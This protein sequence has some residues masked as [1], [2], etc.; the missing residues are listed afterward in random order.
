VGT[1]AILGRHSQNAREIII[2]A[3]ENVVIELGARHLTLDAVAAKAG[4]SKGGLL[5]HFPNKEALLHAMLDRRVA[6]L[7]E[8]R[9]QKLALLPQNP[10][11]VIIAHVRSLLERDERTNKLSVALLAAVAHDP[12]LLVPYQK[13]HKRVVDQFCRTGLSFERAGAI[14]LA[15][16]G[17]KFMELFSLLPFTTAERTRIIEEIIAL[18]EQKKHAR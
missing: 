8:S 16:Q 14:M 6:R 2:D 12:Q 7:D 18:S 15:V 17:L 11:S 4:V 3:A 13:E 1:E 5:Y 10:K 9:Q